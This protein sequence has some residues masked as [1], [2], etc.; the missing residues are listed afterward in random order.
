MKT[1]TIAKENIAGKRRKTK[2]K[3]SATS[4]K[5]PTPFHIKRFGDCCLL[6]IPLLEGYIAGTPI[7]DEN[8]KHWLQFGIGLF[9]VMVKFVTNF[10]SYTEAGVVSHTQPGE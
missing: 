3:V 9:F 7:I 4:Y 10:F 6:A 1:A 5:S 8:V 2:F